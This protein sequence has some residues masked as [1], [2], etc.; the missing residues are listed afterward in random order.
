MRAESKER[1]AENLI[2]E[3]SVPLSME[4]K[5]QELRARGRGAPLPSDPPLED[6]AWVVAGRVRHQEASQHPYPGEDPRPH[7]PERQ[8]GRPVWGAPPS[9]HWWSPALPRVGS[10]IFDHLREQASTIAVSRPGG[11]LPPGTQPPTP[12]GL[13]ERCEQQTVRRPFVAAKRHSHHATHCP[14]PNNRSRSSA[15]PEC[16]DLTELCA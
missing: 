14:R 5:L 13:T 3:V 1:R 10:S 9:P 6:C 15:I 16:R 7:L 8:K 2:S 12:R 11:K 4:R